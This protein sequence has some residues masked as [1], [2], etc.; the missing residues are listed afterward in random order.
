[1]RLREY[2]AAAVAILRE[3]FAQTMVQADGVNEQKICRD[4]VERKAHIY[5]SEKSFRRF[6]KLVVD[7]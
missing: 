2:L 6:W 4:D 7:G 1:V 3:A 5:L